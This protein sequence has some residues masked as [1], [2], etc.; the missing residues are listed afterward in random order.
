MLTIVDILKGSTSVFQSIY[1]SVGE[2]I[3]SY[4][5]YPRMIGE[6]SGKNFH[7]VHKSANI[8]NAALK[9]VRAAFEYQ[10]QKCSACSRAYVPKSCADAFLAEL[11]L[12][13]ESLSMGD[14]LTDFCGPV[15]SEAAYA[16]VSGFVSRAREDA[17]VDVV[18][19]GQWDDSTGYYI[20]CASIH[21]VDQGLTKGNSARRS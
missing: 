3:A 1:A 5:S 11:I 20:V 6:T 15:I 19:G 10:G 7:L 16:R 13:T 12:Q 21:L 4:V 8:R 9:T 18:A 17:G 2:N 14:K